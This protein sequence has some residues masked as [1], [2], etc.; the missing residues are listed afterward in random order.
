[1]ELPDADAEGPAKALAAAAS[2]FVDGNGGQ[3]AEPL[4]PQNLSMVAWAAARMAPSLKKASKPLVKACTK[5]AKRRARELSPRDLVDLVW[6]VAETGLDKPKLLTRFGKTAAGMIDKFNS[7][8]L[9]KLLGLF[10]RA[11]HD[12]EELHV[13]MG[14][15]RDLQYDFPVAIKGGLTVKLEHQPAGRHSVGTGSFSSPLLL[16]LLLF[17]LFWS[18]SFWSSLLSFLLPFM[19]AARIKLCR[20]LH[21]PS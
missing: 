6:A 18:C 15:R 17:S 8:E 14:T 9:L 1:M 3:L 11:G 2:G 20:R 12:A 5:E 13:A 19:V 4:V 10:A 16:L 7:Q 21:P